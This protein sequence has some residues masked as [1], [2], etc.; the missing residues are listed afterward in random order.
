MPTLNDIRGKY[1]EYGYMSDEELAGALHKKFYADMDRAEFDKR[2]G[3]APTEPQQNNMSIGEVATDA[4]KSLGIG[5]AQGAIGFGTLPGNVEGLVRAG[6]NYGASVLGADPVMDPETLMIN[7]NDLKGAL[8][9]K[10]GE[11]YKPK[12]TV[13]EYART[14]GEFAPAALGGGASAATRAATV[15][16]PA[17]TSE[18]AG[19]LTEGTSWEPAA[20]VAGALVGTRVPNM[21][22]RAVTPAPQD[23]LRAAQVARLEQEGVTAMMAGQRTG[24]KIVQGLE[25]A[26]DKFPGGGRIASARAREAAEQYTAAALRRAG[27]NG[28]TADP[29]TLEAAFQNIGR[30]YQ[31]I[32][33]TAAVRA[34]APFV[35][36][37][38]QAVQN[39]RN[40]TPE[41]Q[42]APILQN[43]LDE[44]RARAQ[45]AGAGNM[46]TGE[47]FLSWHS[48]L[49][50]AQRDL[51]TVP[52]ASRAMGNLISTLDAQMVR[53]MPPAARG[54]AARNVRDVN[55]RYRNMLAVEDAA[56][57]GSGEWAALG[58]ISPPSLK[59]AVKRQ[60]PR[61][62]S[63]GRSELARLARAGEAVLRPL[64]S[65][66][67]AE[68]SLMQKF[69][70]SPGAAVSTMG[71][72]GAM[73]GVPGIALAVAPHAITAGM[74]RAVT[75]RPVQRYFGNQTIPQN[76]EP[77]DARGLG[78]LVP[79]MLE[80][81]DQGV[82]VPLQGGFG[83]K[84][85]ETE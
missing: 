67:T 18:T 35:R 81:E 12:T 74:A 42:Q 50:K 66:G 41:A 64:P 9:T 49:R 75:S 60:N 80:R 62:Y 38:E 79:M 13:G 71:V 5:L 30:E 29:D 44:M 57:S 20:R 36:R 39:Y 14:I 16:I 78:A 33:Q 63:R 37:L 40:V 10:T 6:V 84:W 51:K 83:P 59:G 7:Y 55:N 43:L 72:G 76:L 68:R 27:I 3:I 8:E 82:A 70:E 46:M 65:S 47:Q 15:A 11:F 77:L 21:T 1:P 52:G 32:A 45:A 2:V 48:N 26:A 85:E 24:N 73:G 4:V 17:V 56:N 61:D 69:L 54:Q 31:G 28:R 19:Q 25:D 23:P 22:A 53:S 58:L 34:D